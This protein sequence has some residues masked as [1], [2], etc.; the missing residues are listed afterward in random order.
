M[1]PVWE[2]GLHSVLRPVGSGRSPHS[3]HINLDAALNRSVPRFPSRIRGK[4]VSSKEGNAT[5]WKEAGS[6]RPC[7]PLGRARSRELGLSRMVWKDQVQPVAGRLWKRWQVVDGTT[8]TARCFWVLSGADPQISRIREQPALAPDPAGTDARRAP[9]WKG[10][11]VWACGV[12]GP[13]HWAH[14]TVR[15]ALVSLRRDSGRWPVTG[16]LVRI[17]SLVFPQEASRSLVRMC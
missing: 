3:G 10:G 6:S 1:S 2:A 15:E 5:A 12:R 8:E 17:L 13:G 16:S 11:P 7:D 4:R 9:V 14:W